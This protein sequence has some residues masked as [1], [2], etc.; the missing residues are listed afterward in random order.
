MDQVPF[1]SSKEPPKFHH[2]A[3]ALYLEKKEV[4]VN[5]KSKGGTLGLNIKSLMDKA[6]TFVDSESWDDFNVILALLIY[7]VFLFPNIE[8]FMDL[9]SICIFMTKNLVP[10]LFADTYHSIHLRN[11]KYSSLGELVKLTM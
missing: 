8:D 2:M 9:A 7:E 3:E 4:E 1:N 5:L 6:T 11:Q 10:T